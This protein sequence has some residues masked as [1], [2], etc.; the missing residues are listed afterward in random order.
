MFNDY[1]DNAES[2]FKEDPFECSKS[3]HHE[4]NILKKKDNGFISQIYC[5]H[6]NKVRLCMPV[7]VPVPSAKITYIAPRIIRPT[8]FYPYQNQTFK[9]KF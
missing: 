7:G 3:E 8:I 9:P 2:S 4:W 6:C 1:F 5:I